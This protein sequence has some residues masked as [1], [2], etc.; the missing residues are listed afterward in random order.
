MRVESM[1]TSLSWMP[2]GVV[3]GVVRLLFD[4]KILQY[5]TPPP[6]VLDDLAALLSADAVR[7]ANELR[8]WIEIEDGRITGYGYAGRGHIGVTGIRLGG[9]RLVFPAIAFP[10][11]CSE[12]E[13]GDG[14]VRFVQTTGGRLGTPAPRRIRGRP[15]LRIAGP[16][17]WS[18]LAL[19]IR[20][21]GPSDFELIGASSFPRHWIYDHTGRLVDQTALLDFRAW[22][23]AAADH[24]PW[25]DE[26]LP[27][28]MTRI[29]SDLERHLSLAVMELDPPIEHLRMG[30]TLIEKGAIGHEIFSLIDGVIAVEVDGQ[31]VTEVGP[32]AIV[33]DVALLQGGRQTVTLRAITPCRVAVV[34][35]EH[36]ERQALE[37]LAKSRPA[38]P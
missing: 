13:V 23:R 32:G 3:E 12:P 34:P 20:A 26:D 24:N 18:T 33:G 19:T 31:A 1:V 38:G 5:D 29:A 21:V 6:G 27:A 14:W 37:E 30:E 36:I 35:H 11:L 15:F 7:F 25:V 10:D 2:R 16:T 4:L 8:A 17:M 9:R 28:A 22:Y